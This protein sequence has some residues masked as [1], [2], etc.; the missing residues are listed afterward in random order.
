MSAAAA[1]AGLWAP[2]LAIAVA[3]VVL[4]LPLLADIVLE[5]IGAARYRP[6]RV[7]AFSL[8]GGIGLGVLAS[9]PSRLMVVGPL[10][11]LLPASAAVGARMSARRR[12]AEGQTA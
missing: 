1:A 2:S 9:L 11:G 12:M 4:G 3:G 5:A 10:L 6:C 7:A 8:L